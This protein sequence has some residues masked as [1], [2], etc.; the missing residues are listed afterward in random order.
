MFPPS[1]VRR[2]PAWR[3]AAIMAAVVDFP[4]EPVTPIDRV[5][6]P[7][8]EAGRGEQSPPGKGRSRSSAGR[9][10]P[11]RWPARGFSGRTAGL[12]TT[13]SAWR[14]SSSRC[15]PRWKAAILA[16]G[17]TLQRGRQGFF[18]RQIGHGDDRAL[19]CKPAGRGR[20]AAKMAQAHDGCSL[21]AIWHVV[22]KVAGTVRVPSALR[23]QPQAFSY[24]VGCSESRHFQRLHH[25]VH[26]L[27]RPAAYR[28][29]IQ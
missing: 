11:V 21:S 1:Q 15:P 20:P 16:V 17:Q 6:S 22:P 25:A 24:P 10:F 14:K 4:L 2:P 13:R 27:Q 26:G 28:F 29:N 12:T 5:P 7:L 8:G 23:S 18:I 3:M 19:R 9:R